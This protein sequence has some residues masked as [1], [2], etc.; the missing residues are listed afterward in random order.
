[1]N[2]NEMLIEQYRKKINRIAWRLQDRAK[3]QRRCECLGLSEDNN[4]KTM[5]FAEGCD[6]ALS[7]SQYL[8]ALPA[9]GK[10]IIQNIYME[11]KTEAQVAQELQMTQQAV[12][13]WKKN[14]LKRLYRTMSSEH[15]CN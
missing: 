14:M 7:V 9:R 4:G 15:M 10:V 5:S 11:D 12:N 2:S 13:K 8:E 6:R 3:V 1:M